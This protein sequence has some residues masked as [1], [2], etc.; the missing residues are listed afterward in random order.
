MSKGKEGNKE[1]KVGRNFSCSKKQ[2]AGRSA[3]HVPVITA[4]DSGG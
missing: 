1:E 4:L 3:G 2:E